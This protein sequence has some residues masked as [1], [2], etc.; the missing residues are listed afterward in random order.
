M[1]AFK[2]TNKCMQNITF[3]LKS[4]HEFNQTIFKLSHVIHILINII[5]YASCEVP[6]KFHQIWNLLESQ[7]CKLL[8]KNFFLSFMSIM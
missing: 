6:T 5:Y 7:D 3:Y 4:L 1:S 2:I 8:Q